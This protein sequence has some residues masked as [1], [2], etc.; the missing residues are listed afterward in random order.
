LQQPI[1]DMP[2]ASCRRFEHRSTVR[3]VTHRIL[4]GRESF[5]SRLGY[6]NEFDKCP[7]LLS[8]GTRPAAPWGER[9]QSSKHIR[10]FGSWW[11]AI[12]TRPSSRCSVFSSL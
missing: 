3:R 11:C 7:P 6:D 10:K 9:G 12:R 2:S 8:V 5:D 4:T 1:A